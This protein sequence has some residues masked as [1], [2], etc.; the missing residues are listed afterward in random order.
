MGRLRS[1]RNLHKLGFLLVAWLL[2]SVAAFATEVP[3]L[4]QPRC[5]SVTGR[6]TPIKYCPE[7]YFC[8]GT[9][10]RPLVGVSA[11]AGCHIPLS[12]ATVCNRSNAKDV[13]D[14]IADEGLNKMRLWVS[15]AGNSPFVKNDLS[16]AHPFVYVSQSRYWRLDCPNETYFKKLESVVDYASQPSNDITVEVTFFAPGE[17]TFSGGPWDGKTGKGK[18]CVNKKTNEIKP[19]D[20]ECTCNAPYVLKDA[21]FSNQSCGGGAREFADP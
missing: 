19:Y 18:A 20:K 9:E 3:D 21:G 1:I 10:L 6:I 5:G 2:A 4:K 7:R 8:T 13:I 12:D 11:D 14:S 17:G 16:S 15:L